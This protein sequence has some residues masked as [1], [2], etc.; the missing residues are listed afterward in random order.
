MLLPPS[1]ANS[2]FFIEVELTYNVVLVSD[3]QQS[4]SVLHIHIILHSFPLW[5]I[6]G[7]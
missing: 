7:Y 3:V 6:T 5:F 4:D 1:E 2:F